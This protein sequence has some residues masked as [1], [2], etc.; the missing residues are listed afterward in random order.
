MPTSNSI[1]KSNGARQAYQGF[2][3][4]NKLVDQA[5]KNHNLQTALYRHNT[6]KN[7]QQAVSGFIEEARESTR[8]VDFKKGTLFVACLSREIA[9]QIRLLTQR[10]IYALNQLLGRQV[11]FA[12]SVEV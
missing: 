4:I 12:I 8:A 5:A 7:W 9:A 6:L 3:K 11:V 10:I 2:T 1:K